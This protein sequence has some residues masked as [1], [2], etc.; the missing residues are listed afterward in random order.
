[1]TAIAERTQ[2]ANI[3]IGSTI[4]AVGTSLNMRLIRVR[5]IPHV[6]SMY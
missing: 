6:I 2:T 5:P 1:M 3:I 4:T